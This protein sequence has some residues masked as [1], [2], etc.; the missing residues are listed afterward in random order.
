MSLK[1]S[2]IE[3]FATWCQCQEL[4]R[5]FNLSS[6]THLI[7]T[8][9]C[10]SLRWGCGLTVEGSGLQH[11]KQGPL[12]READQVRHRTCSQMDCEQVLSHFLALMIY[13]CL[14]FFFTFISTDIY[15]GSFQALFC[16]V[17][18][19]KPN[20]DVCWVN[21]A[22]LGDF[23]IWLR[24]FAE[25]A[26]AQLPKTDSVRGRLVRSDVGVRERSIRNDK[27]EGAS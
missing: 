2:N 3:Y 13:W 9:H 21:R 22:F 27:A 20:T 11:Q 16:L 24:T 19:T 1:K 10:P 15:L 7:A 26:W 25:G 23:F 12:K 8:S 4:S 17:L 18:Q 6:A 5:S 14:G